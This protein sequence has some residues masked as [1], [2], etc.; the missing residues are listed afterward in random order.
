MSRYALFDRTAIALRPLAERGHDLLADRCRRLDEAIEPYH[1]PDFP[2]L[3]ERIKLARRSGRPVIAMIGGHPIKLGLSRYLIDLIERRIVTHLATNGAGIIHDFELAMI[4]GTSEDVAKWIK[5]GQFGLWQETGRL[6]EVISEAADRGEGLGEAVGRVIEEQ[7]FPFRDL[8]L[9]AAGWRTGTPITSH[10]SVGSDIN[11]A[12]P[13]CDGAAL[14]QASFTDFLIFARTVQN[15]EGGVFLNIG[16]AV[17]GPEV[18]LKALSM[19]RNVERISASPAGNPPAPP[20]PGARIA[21]CHFTTA[22]FDMAPLPANWRDCTPTRDEAMYYYRPWKTILV[23]TVQDGGESFYIGGDHRQTIPRLW[24]A[25]TS[26][27]IQP[28]G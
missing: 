19:A 18:Y 7:Q 16:S 5:V 25:L 21:P 22:V 10:V 23:R 26:S 17:T 11:H 4:G 24:Q 6:N 2:Q 3:I 12:M 13:S 28:A 1:A 8:S 9:A 15:L 27:G 20:V 14:G